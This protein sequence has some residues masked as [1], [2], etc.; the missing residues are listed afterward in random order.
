VKYL[1]GYLDRS[2]CADIAARFDLKGRLERAKAQLRIV[3]SPA[4]V[5][6]LQHTLGLQPL[7][8]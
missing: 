8:D 7:A 5:A 1:E 4:Y 3:E 6:S 2:N